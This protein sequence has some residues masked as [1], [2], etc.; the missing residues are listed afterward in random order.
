MT[1]KILLIYHLCCPLGRLR[2]HLPKGRPALSVARPKRRR[3]RLWSTSIDAQTS[4]HESEVSCKTVEEASVE[5]GLNEPLS[6]KSTLARQGRA[7]SRAKLPLSDKGGKCPRRHAVKDGWASSSRTHRVAC[8]EKLRL[9]KGL[10]DRKV[11]VARML[12]CSRQP[13]AVFALPS[14]PILSVTEDL[15]LLETTDV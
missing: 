4:N 5:V 12:M 8:L 10:F 6:V 13:G 2:S 14:G 11:S 1:R 15:E 7:S 3:L 9:A